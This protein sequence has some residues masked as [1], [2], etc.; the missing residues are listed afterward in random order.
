M[1]ERG[2][3][4][5]RRTGRARRGTVQRGGLL[6][7]LRV[8]RGWRGEGPARTNQKVVRSYRAHPGAGKISTLNVSVATGIVLLQA[9][10]QRREAS[11][12]SER[13]ESV[14]SRLRR[15]NHDGSFP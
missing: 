11:S 5:D 6:R 8:R 2:K 13:K 1:F 10:R 3:L 4:L 9:A 12:G 15:S 7:P 14:Q